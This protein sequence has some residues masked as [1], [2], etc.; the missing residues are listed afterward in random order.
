[1]STDEYESI[2]AWAA[3]N[4]YEAANA[5][6]MSKS[7]SSDPLAD[8]DEATIRRVLVERVGDGWRERPTSWKRADNALRLF[9]W[10]AL[11]ETATRHLAPPNWHTFCGIDAGERVNAYD[12]VSFDGSPGWCEWCR[13]LADHPDQVEPWCV[14]P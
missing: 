7:G 4:L 1:M 2:E 6:R 14:P 3:L 11:A 5:L 13:W 10:A 8:E 9:V 12:T